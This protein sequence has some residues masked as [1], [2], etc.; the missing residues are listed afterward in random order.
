MISERYRQRRKI[1][2]KNKEMKTQISIKNFINLK[3]ELSKRKNLDLVYTTSQA[4]GYPSNEVTAIVGFSTLET[5]E[6]FAK[7]YGLSTVVLH[8]RDGWN[9]WAR[10]YYNI[11]RP[12]Q[13]SRGGK[14]MSISEDTHS[15]IIGVA[16]EN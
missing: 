7:K 4:N 2:L 12:L 11:L 13:G 10:M 15:W 3:K 5:A 14:V 16:C 1:N 8:K 6:N 9:F